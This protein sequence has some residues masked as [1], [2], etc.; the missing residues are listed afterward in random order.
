VTQNLRDHTLK[1]GQLDRNWYN[2][3]KNWPIFGGV[4]DVCILLGALLHVGLCPMK[5]SIRNAAT[6]QTEL[7]AIRSSNKQIYTHGFC[8]KPSFLSRALDASVTKLWPVRMILEFNVRGAGPW[9][10]A[11]HGLEPAEV[12]PL[13]GPFVLL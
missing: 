12:Q 1:L 13:V 11:V 9:V 10:C 6:V 7:I 2:W 8:F 5:S 3:H 4:V